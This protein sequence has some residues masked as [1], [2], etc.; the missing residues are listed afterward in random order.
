MT[1]AYQPVVPVIFSKSTQ[2]LKLSEL[3]PTDYVLSLT[4]LGIDDL[5]ALLGDPRLRSLMACDAEAPR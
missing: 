3:L 5:R 4:I 1:I 2:S